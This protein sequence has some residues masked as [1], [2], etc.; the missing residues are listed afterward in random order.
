MAGLNIE[1]VRNQNTITIYSVKNGGEQ[2]RVFS[3]YL[4]SPLGRFDAGVSD[5]GSLTQQLGKTLK[6]LGIVGD[7]INSRVG[8]FAKSF[9]SGGRLGVGQLLGTGVEYANAIN[10]NMNYRFTGTS[11]FSHG[12]ECELVV[13]DDFID[14][15]IVPLW[16]IISYV[17]PDESEPLK[18]TNLYKIISG[19]INS[20]GGWVKDKV[21]GVNAENPFIQQD[22][23]DTFWKYISTV[24]GEVGDMAGSVTVLKK[25][26]QLQG[27]MSHSRITIGDYIEIDDVIVESVGFSLPYLLYEGGLFDNVKVSIK[28]KGNRKMTLKTYDWIKQLVRLEGDFPMESIPPHISLNEQFSPKLKTKQ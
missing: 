4:T 5:Y 21:N 18:D 9:M 24:G 23:L 2:S 1:S 15:V 8:Q 7:V 25:P 12:F 10:Y 11:E 20:A 6:G 26:L 22:A 16:N 28:V 19:G 14:D 3:A 27:G 17:L 13:K